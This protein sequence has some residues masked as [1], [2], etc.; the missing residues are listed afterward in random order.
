MTHWHQHAFGQLPDGARVMLATIQADHGSRRTFPAVLLCRQ[1]GLYRL[2]RD[3]RCRQLAPGYCWP[4][5]QGFAAELSLRPCVP[6]MWGNQQG[7][8]CVIRHIPE[9][10]LRARTGNLARLL[11]AWYQTGQALFAARVLRTD[12][13]LLSRVALPLAPIWH[14]VAITLLPSTDVVVRAL[15][16]GVLLQRL[17]RGLERIYISEITWIRAP[18]IE[19]TLRALAHRFPARLVL[20]KALRYQFLE[21]VLAVKRVRASEYQFIGLQL[22]ERYEDDFGYDR[23]DNPAALAVMFRL[24]VGA[25]PRGLRLLWIHE[26]VLDFE[27]WAGLDVD[28]MLRI[29]QLADA[30]RAEQDHQA[31][32]ALALMLN[33]RRKN[34]PE[35]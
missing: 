28:G 33:D 14:P 18:R 2:W 21:K 20:V 5:G 22:Q 8:S 26:C 25:V 11:I 3:G 17:Q 34:D 4:E 13:L 7:S 30:R 10:I 6:K 35:R 23:Y 31:R 9:R 24:R 15:H 16:T 1:D 12:R 19:A 27:Q 32:A 29:E